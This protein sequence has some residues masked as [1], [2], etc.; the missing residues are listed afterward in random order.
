MVAEVEQRYEIDPT[1]LKIVDLPGHIQSLEAMARMF[2]IQAF[3]AKKVLIAHMKD[4]GLMDYTGDNGSGTFTIRLEPTGKY[5]RAMWTPLKEIFTDEQF[6]VTWLPEEEKTTVTPGRWHEGRVKSAIRD[7]A[8]A[9]I[10]TG[11]KVLDDSW[12]PGDPNLVIEWA[13]PEPSEEAD[14]D[15]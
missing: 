15:A 1:D 10:M 14:V 12:K 11:Q 2:E 3:E 6:K 8:N 13:A 5:D 9:G 7:M 4:N